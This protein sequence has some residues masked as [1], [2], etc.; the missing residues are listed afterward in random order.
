MNTK[1]GSVNKSNLSGRFHDDE[2]AGCGLIQSMSAEIYNVR[3]I[4]VNNDNNGFISIP[5]VENKVPL[6]HIVLY[7]YFT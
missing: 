3:N 1:D 6:Y 2:S 7:K 5:R 4:R